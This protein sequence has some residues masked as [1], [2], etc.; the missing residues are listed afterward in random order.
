MSTLPAPTTESLPDAIESERRK[1]LWSRAYGELRKRLSE[2][3]ES[4]LAGGAHRSWA[5]DGLAE[6]DKLNAQAMRG[7]VQEALA[8]PWELGEKKIWAAME[9]SFDSSQDSLISQ[10]AALILKGLGSLREPLRSERLRFFGA[11]QMAEERGFSTLGRVASDNDPSF[12]NEIGRLSL[13]SL[14]ALGGGCAPGAPASGAAQLAGA[15]SANRRAKKSARKAMTLALEGLRQLDP[16]CAQFALMT[17]DPPRSNLDEALKF[18][19]PDPAL[20]RKA[21]EGAL[22]ERPALL[23]LLSRHQEGE[24][25]LEWCEA[26]GFQGARWPGSKIACAIGMDR[27]ADFPRELTETEAQRHRDDPEG[28]TALMRSL[29]PAEPLWESDKRALAVE[30]GEDPGLAAEIALEARWV[31]ESVFESAPLR[32]LAWDSLTRRLGCLLPSRHASLVEWAQDQGD[33]GARAMACSLAL[34]IGLADLPESSQ[35][36]LRAVAFEVKRNFA[37]LP[38]GSPELGARLERVLL[39]AHSGAQGHATPAKARRAGL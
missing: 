28:L 6:R 17:L 15:V 2:A 30:L 33:A 13:A 16:G 12:A 10:T 8:D 4:W 22:L 23:H 38:G 36:V 11:M 37:S 35:W 39:G 3:R 20:Y 26:A 14:L 5:P 32:A 19:W 24:K 9:Q 27:R 21:F 7:W 29:D 18:E 1:E 25:V 34:R 31:C